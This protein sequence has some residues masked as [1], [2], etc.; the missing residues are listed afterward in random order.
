LGGVV[1]DVAGKSGQAGDHPR[2]IGDADFRTAT[3]VYGIGLV[4]AFRRQQYAFGAVVGVQELACG[5][6]GSP[7]C[8]LPFALLH[9]LHTFA[10]QRGDNM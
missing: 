9:R 8:D 4:V 7:D 3:E 10:N 1:N 6:A 5:R 2:Q